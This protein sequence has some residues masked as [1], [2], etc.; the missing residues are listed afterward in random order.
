MCTITTITAFY[1]LHICI[2]V[3]VEMSELELGLDKISLVRRE[4]QEQER[5]F[6]MLR[7][8]KA[9]TRLELQKKVSKNLQH[10]IQRQ[11]QEYEKQNLSFLMQG[12]FC[13]KLVCVRYENNEEY[14]KLS[15]DPLDVLLIILFL[16]DI[17]V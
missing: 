16:L 12:I 11:K 8:R 1:L 9:A 10:Q 5:N 7:A 6:H 4:V 17:R 14:C 15:N 3:R 2:L 13:L